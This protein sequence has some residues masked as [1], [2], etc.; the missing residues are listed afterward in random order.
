MHGKTKGSCSATPVKEKST[1][2][3]IENF[4]KMKQYDFEYTDQKFL[5]I[6]VISCIVLLAA[7]IAGM[8]YLAP[9]IGKLPLVIL[10]IAGPFVVFFLYKKRIKKPGTAR[11]EGDKVT[12]NLSGQSRTISFNELIS[13]KIE[14]FNGTR[15]HLTFLDNSS[16]KLVSNNNLGGSDHFEIFCDDLE[17]ALSEYIH[18]SN[19]TLIRKPSVFEQKWFPYLLGAIT[20]A[21]GWVV[22]DAFSS[23]NKPPGSIY[24]S[25][26][27]FISLWAAYFKTRQKN[28]EKQP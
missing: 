20:L 21:L 16:F 4:S 5:I 3:N 26:A 10:A 22:I 2:V 24:V 1:W 6:L 13:Y 8:L 23:G 12:F 9:G 28:R 17:K 25:I 14:H 19:T 15:L 27:I 7:L 18:A 11:L